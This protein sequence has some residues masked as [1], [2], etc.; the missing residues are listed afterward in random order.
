MEARI[1][2]RTVG[3]GFYPARQLRREE[4]LQFFTGPAAALSEEQRRAAVRLVASRDLVTVMTAPA[5]AGKTTS[6]AA[7][8]AVWSGQHTDIVALAPSARAAAELA[9]A[10]GAQGQTV[11]RWLFK[12]ANDPTPV[13]RPRDA[14]YFRGEVIIVDEASMLATADL[15]RLTRYVAT[16]RA[17]L[18]L[19]GTPARSVR[20]TH[21]AAC[22]NTSS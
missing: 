13:L 9:A 17:R 10:T 11:A 4:L 3:G 2:E 21:R 6:L 8:V 12:E 20:S 1:V 18:V 16:H 15:D 22:S 7:A 14:G 5:G 19:V